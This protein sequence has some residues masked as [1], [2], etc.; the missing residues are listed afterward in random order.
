MRTAYFITQLRRI[1]YKV[2]ISK[3]LS[4]ETINIKR[5]SSLCRQNYHQDCEDA[6]NKQ[7]N[8]ELYASYVYMSMV[9][10]ENFYQ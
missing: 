3:I 7:I 9:N 6:I 10:V 1:S 8:M 4:K 5:M 2:D